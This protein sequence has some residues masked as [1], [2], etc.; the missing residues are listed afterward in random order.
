MFCLKVSFRSKRNECLLLFYIFHLRDER[1]ED[2]GGNLGNDNYQQQFLEGQGSGKDREIMQQR[3]YRNNMHVGAKLSGSN[4]LIENSEVQAAKLKS[5]NFI[6]PPEDELVGL[7]VEEKKRK[8][9]GPIQDVAMLT[10]GSIDSINP[11][12]VLSN[13]DCSVSSSILWA[14]SAQQTSQLL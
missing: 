6:G 9:N 12:V 1:D 10:D 2:W 5:N 11:E 14:K 8:K 4:L 13:M 7:S 3:D